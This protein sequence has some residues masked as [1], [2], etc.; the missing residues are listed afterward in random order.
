MNNLLLTRLTRLTD[1]PDY[2]GDLSR[3]VRVGSSRS[4]GGHE[5]LLSGDA[6]ILGGPD[7]DDESN[8]ELGADEVDNL[9]GQLVDYV[10]I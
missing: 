10:R 7:H 4:A 5:R 3:S 6:M 9:V 8:E 2:S 1:L